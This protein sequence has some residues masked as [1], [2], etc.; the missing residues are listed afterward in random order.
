MQHPKQIPR[1]T[2]QPPILQLRSHVSL[3]IANNPNE[4][5]NSGSKANE[6]VCFAIEQLFVVRNGTV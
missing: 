3:D 2:Q 1:T 6:I 4:Q 5:H